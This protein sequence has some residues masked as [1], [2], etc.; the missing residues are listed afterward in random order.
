ML[1]QE[2]T[3]NVGFDVEVGAKTDLGDLGNAVAALDDALY[4]TE[5]EAADRAADL[6]RIV[7][8]I[9]IEDLVQMAGNGGEDMMRLLASLFSVLRRVAERGDREAAELLF[10]LGRKMT[11]AGVQTHTHTCGCMHFTNG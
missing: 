1:T 4:R 11:V 2:A 5:S 6:V 9:G 7:N 3:R 10:T 8:E